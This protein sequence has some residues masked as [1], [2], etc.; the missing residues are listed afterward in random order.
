MDGESDPLKGLALEARLR[1]GDGVG[2]R[3]EGVN[4]PRPDG[5]ESRQPAAS[6]SDLEHGL[7]AQ[8]GHTVDRLRLCARCIAY[9]HIGSVT[10]IIRRC[11]D[12]PKS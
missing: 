6:A 4:E 5:G 9:V 10:A 12:R 7:A 2:V 1:F 11:R 3:V 8:V